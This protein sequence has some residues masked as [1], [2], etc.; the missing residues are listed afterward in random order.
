MKQNDSTKIFDGN[1]FSLNIING[2]VE[3]DD[4]IKNSIV[5]F[6]DDINSVSGDW[7]AAQYQK[8]DLD[9]DVKEI[10]DEPI[11]DKLL[12]NKETVK[13][14]IEHLSTRK[15]DIIPRRKNT[16]FMAD[17]ALS[18][19]D[20]YAILKQL[21]VGDYS[22]SVNS[23]S[24]IHLNNVLTVFITGKDFELSDG[25]ILKDLVL[26]I[27]VDDTEEGWVTV[28]S[29]HESTHPEEESHPYE[30]TKQDK[31]NSVYEEFNLYET[32]WDNN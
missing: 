25:R 22:Y 2:I 7:V 21:S 27:K 19:E 1:D 20:L 14:S 23:K 4:I 26:Y 24:L 8:D 28:I 32:L 9:E 11:V 17:N 13:D 31:P 30:E 12:V 3:L 5:V 10:K 15:I 16:K 6:T 18:K 29:I